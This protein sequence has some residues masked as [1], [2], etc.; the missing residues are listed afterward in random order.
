[1]RRRLDWHKTGRGRPKLRFSE[2]DNVDVNSNLKIDPKTV[3]FL[4]VG[5]AQK[6]VLQFGKSY[7]QPKYYFWS[8]PRESK[9]GKLFRLEQSNKFRY[10]SS[11]KSF[12]EV[13]NDFKAL[14]PSK[15][16]NFKFTN[17]LICCANSYISPHPLSINIRNLVQKNFNT[18]IKTKCKT[19]NTKILDLSKIM[20]KWGRGA[21]FYVFYK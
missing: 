19:Q 3:Q 21:S 16:K 17:L 13:G 20:A 6:R 11:V 9:L 2:L 7:H 15:F 1:M 4:E 18:T 5:Q 10:S 14:Q 8:F 12:K